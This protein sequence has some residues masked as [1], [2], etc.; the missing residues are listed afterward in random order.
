MAVRLVVADDHSVIRG[1]LRMYLQADP[2]I[3]LEGEA[4]DGRE[5]VELSQ[6]LQPDVV[7]MDLLM[8]AMDGIEATRAIRS[9]LPYVEVVAMTTILESGAMPDAINAGAIACVLKDSQ[10]QRLRHAILAA[11]AGQVAFFTNDLKRV[12]TD[13]H[14]SD[15]PPGSLD[16]Q[17]RDL[18]RLIAIGHSDEEMTR[19]LGVDLPVLRSRVEGVLLRLGMLGRAQAL[20]YAVQHGIASWE[21]VP[22]LADPPPVDASQS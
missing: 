2:E 14:V 9:E 11:H 4:R 21:E 8:P 19:D 15:M 10:P 5:A 13:L 22:A 18:L 7:L 12:V 3:Q 20:V 6:R 16:Q 1:A 17:Q